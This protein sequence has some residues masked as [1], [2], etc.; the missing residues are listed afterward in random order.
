[1]KKIFYLSTFIA[2]FF[3]ISNAYAYYNITNVNTTIIL[4]SNQSARV[5]ELFTV[6][7]S[8]SSIASYQ[9]SKDAIGITLSDWQKIIYGGG[10]VQHIYGSGSSFYNFEFLPGPIV[11][12]PGG[13]YATLT[14]NY[15][16]KN[17]TTVK[18]IAPRKFEYTLNDSIFNF[19]E[20]QSGQILPTNIRLNIIMPTGAKITTIYPLPD[21]PKPNLIDNYTNDTEFSWFTGEPLSQFAFQYVI[22][23]SPEA[24]VVSYFQGIY[25]KYNIEIYLIIVAAII[26]VVL[27]VT[28]KNKSSKKDK[29]E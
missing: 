8:N 7:V 1:M 17:A 19:Q 21:Y 12:V 3:F 24:E 22:T 16:I 11:N 18:N 5:V 2:V 20:E 9:Q 13:G 29:E 28:V 27:R 26:F 6:Y 25:T 15:Y 23:E 10:L 4:N 14:M